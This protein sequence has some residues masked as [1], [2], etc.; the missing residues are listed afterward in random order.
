MGKSLL[1]N[2]PYNMHWQHPALVNFLPKYSGIVPPEANA[3]YAFILSG[4]SMIDEKA[5]FLLTNGVLSTNQKEE[6][7][8]RKMLVETNLL[9]AVITLPDNMFESTNIPVCI[10]LFDKHKQTAETEMIDARNIYDV[11]MRD[12]RGQ[13][14]CNSHT[15]RVYHKEIKVLTDNHVQRIKNAIRDRVNEK[16][17]CRVVTIEDIKKQEYILTPSRYIESDNAENVHRSYAEI[18]KDY[19]NIIRQHNEIKLTLNETAAKRLG[20]PTDTYKSGQSVDLSK[21][22]EVVGC[23]AE[24]S[25]YIN[26]TKSAVIRIEIDTKSGIPWII[27]D[28]MRAWTVRERMLN[29]MENKYLAEFRDALL[30]DIISGKIV[31]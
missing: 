8:I 27:Q 13:F 10:L 1:S 4:L 28:F 20:I 6:Q 5:A 3:N 26:F 21:S 15:G 30:P 24:A 12:Q 9:S 16:G 25:N 22:F 7:T 18:A 19:N 2:P 17:F 23:K 31:L 29:D 11:E 14:G